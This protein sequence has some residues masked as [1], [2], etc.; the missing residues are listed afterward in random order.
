MLDATQNLHETCMYTM[1]V[2]YMFVNVTCM[3]ARNMHSGH[4][5][6]VHCA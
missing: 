3:V 6:V 2:S 1:Q 5:H 4:M